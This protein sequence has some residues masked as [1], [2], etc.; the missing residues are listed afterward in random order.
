M[1]FG[2]TKKTV[3]D[4]NKA[5]S[6]L[7][8]QKAEELLKKKSEV[9][10][11]E[12]IEDLAFQNEEK[13]KRADE[14]LIANQELAFQ[15]QEKAKRADELF[16][17]NKELTFQSEQKTKR[18]DELVIANKELAFQNEEK[19]KRAAELIVAKELIVFQEGL[20]LA[21]NQALKLS[22]ELQ[23]Q[24]VELEALNVELIAAQ[25]AAE[26]AAEKYLELYDFAPTGYLSLSSLGEITEINVCGTKMLGEKRLP[27]QGAKFGFFVSNDTKPIFNQFFDKVFAG[28]VEES[29]EVTLSEIGR[30]LVYVHLTGIVNKNGNQCFLTMVD[31]TERRQTVELLQSKM[32]L[33]DAK[34]NATIDG[35]LVI[36]DNNKRFLI[37]QRMID[38][39]RIPPSILEDEDDTNLLEYV[40][41][42]V[43]YPDKFLER[44]MHLYNHR[45]ETSQDEI[46]L[47]NGTIL[48]RYSAPVIGQV[49]KYYGR[50]W[51]FRD[52]TRRKH[53]E[54]EIIKTRDEANK[55]NL[56]KSEFLSRMSHELR[57]PMNSI[58]GFAQLMEMGD[59]KASHKKWLNNIQNS[60]KH[61][62]SLINEVLE[63][64]GIESGRQ[65][66][67]PEPVQ[68]SAILYEISDVVQILADKRKI[69]IELVDSSA[70]NLIVLA[71]IL[72][73][74]QVLLNLTS[75][76]IKYNREGGSV[77]VK[78]ALQP[79]D[80][81]GNA[82]VRISISDTGNG[83]KRED[84]TRLFQ[85]FGRIG[86]DKTKTEGT[87]LGLVVVKEL[88]K[89]MNGAVGVESTVDVGSTFWI[90]LPLTENIK[91]D[92][93]KNKEDIKPT[94]E[95]AIANIEPG[96]QCENE[97]LARSAD[98][99][100][101]GTILYIEDNTSNTE[102]VEQILLN[103]RPAIHLVS[104]T[105]GAQAVSLAIEFDPDLILLDL[106]LPDIKGFEVIKLLQA[107]EKTKEIPVVII[108]ADAMPNQIEKLIKAGSKD[109]LI[110]PLDILAFLD[111]VDNWLGK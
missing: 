15:N 55:A 73:L 21:N 71:D 63:L 53:A 98:P 87:G 79:T 95:S 103:H 34:K 10:I 17:A 83:I 61:L 111:V 102:L 97:L 35:V 54:E 106:D 57:T 92:K 36:D 60:G 5:D 30:P 68:I 39:F 72:R 70:N 19:I 88:M 47:K 42:L 6:A 56:A 45:E 38:I 48:D 91:S 59:L 94:A 101:T 110:K 29:C 74:K 40:V 4:N 27:L 43:K 75:N 33:L 58:L 25:S 86:A 31:I 82:T 65:I 78:T 64:A 85:P 66:L 104:H 7:L 28:K 105:N 77:H 37:N 41:S 3:K 1:N 9:K 93:Q 46:E 8:R 20:I 99:E 49:G 2:K 107:A 69:T 109:Y 14:L 108:S 84:I 16:I 52:V 100:K 22:D 76:A 26:S 80:A 23:A 32:A 67:K 51:T 62:L 96:F 81:H 13:T 24:H 18:A 11:L 50:I 89:A 12:L 44:V 90:D